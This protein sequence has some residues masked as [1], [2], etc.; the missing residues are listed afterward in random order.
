MFFETEFNRL[1]KSRQY[2]ISIIMADINHLQGINK[3]HGFHA[4][5]EMVI[6]VTRLFANSFRNEDI[7]TR[8]GG[9]EFAV[10]LP[11]TGEDVVQ[12]I[13]NRI[14]RQTQEFNSENKDHPI[15]ITLGHAT[16]NRGD[17]VK[18]CLKLAA[19]MIQ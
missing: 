13:L 1:E 12:I 5:D 2:P 19:H 17:S 4:G 18:E 15:Q 3:R 11:S 10:L 6:N 16:A 7:I 9:D 8:Y 14:S